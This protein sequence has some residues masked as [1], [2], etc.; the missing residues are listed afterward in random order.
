MKLVEDWFT[1]QAANIW[2][3]LPDEVMEADAS[4]F[5]KDMD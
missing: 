4:L 5:K 3:E 2:N 1:E